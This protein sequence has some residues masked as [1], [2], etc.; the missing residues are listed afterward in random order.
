MNE[1][2]AP[3][4]GQLQLA[5]SRRTTLIG[6]IMSTVGA[7]VGLRTGYIAIFENERYKLL[8]ESNRV[9]LTL[10][11]PRRGWFIDRVGKPIATN[12]ADFRVD[13]IPDRLVNKEATVKTLSQLLT[14]DQDDVDRITREINEV[15]GFQPVEVASGLDY[16]SFARVSVRLPDLPGVSPRQGFSRYYPSGAAVGHLLGYVGTVSAEEYKERKDPLLITPGFKVGKDSLE[17][18]LEP[19]LQGKPGAKRTEVTAQLCRAAHGG[20]IGLCRGHRLPDW[21]YPRHGLHALFR[22]QQLFRRHWPDGMEDA[23]PG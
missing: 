3:T 10:I 17:K 5:F 7:V 6:G 21:R 11:P 14:L 15:Q 12:R 1:G 2:R 20:G 18:A 9:N 19:Q 4:T 23:E 13:I 8:S 22:S 16:E